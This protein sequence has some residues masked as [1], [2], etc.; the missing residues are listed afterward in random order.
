MVTYFHTGAEGT[1]AG[2][3]TAPPIGKMVE[4]IR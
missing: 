3:R 2:T 4:S 1:H